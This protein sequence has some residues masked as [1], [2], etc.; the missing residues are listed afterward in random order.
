MDSTAKAIP[1]AVPPVATPAPSQGL[2]LI[3]IFELVKTAL[4]LIAGVRA[5]SISSTATRRSS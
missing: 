3:A 2:M 5:C 1:A 4:F